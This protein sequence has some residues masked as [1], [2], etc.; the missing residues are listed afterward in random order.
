[1]LRYPLSLLPSGIGPDT[2]E[3][4]PPPRLW[5]G[6]VTRL[7]IL[8]TKLPEQPNGEKQVKVPLQLRPWQLPNSE[9]AP[10]PKNK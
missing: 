1:M 4:Q 7:N 10:A 3:G 8:Q 9:V 2:F 5:H 6:G